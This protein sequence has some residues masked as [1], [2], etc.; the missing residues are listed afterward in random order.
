MTAGRRE[1]K[2]VIRGKNGKPLLAA[3]CLISLLAP[4]AAAHKDKVSITATQMGVW[5]DMWSV[6]HTC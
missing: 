4:A 2:K 3:R 6:Q 5:W 1:V